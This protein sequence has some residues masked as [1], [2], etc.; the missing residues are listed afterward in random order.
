VAAGVNTHKWL[1]VVMLALNSAV[2]L[3]YYIKLIATMFEQQ[4]E[5]ITRADDSLHPSI[6]IISGVTMGG[7]VSLLLWIGIFPDTLMVIIKDLLA[8]R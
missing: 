2:G 7:L 8:V 1:L 4:P 6:Y 3:Y 5:R